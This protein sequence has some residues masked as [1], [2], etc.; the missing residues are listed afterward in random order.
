MTTPISDLLRLPAGPVDL[1]ALDPRAT[2][3][4][5]GKDK[6][7][8]PKLMAELAPVLDDRQ[9]RLFAAGR[10]DPESAPR[11]LMILQGMDTSGKGGV[12]RHAVGLMDPQGVRITGFKAPTEEE[13]SH[14]FLW[15]IER[16]L[17]SPGQVGI[18]DR[19]QYEDVL[20]VRVEQLVDE[21]E[22]RSR[23]D[24]INEFEARL[25][26][27]GTL[28][29]KCF[30]NVSYAKQGERLMERL[31]NPDK[32]W[33]YNPGDLVARSRWADYQA[34]YADALANCNTE[35]APWYVIPADRKWY[36]NWAAAQ[37]LAEQLERLNLGWPPADFDV[38][39]QKRL[40]AAT[41]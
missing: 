37:L 25:A 11:V 28:I 19:S 22:W 7:D 15:R 36:R 2:H 23:Y 20:V 29:I 26:E 39:E 5:P 21:A 13:R 1:S 38:A 34:A 40:L 6:S 9:E 35:V 14:D 30:L 32:Y 10:A 3:G 8:Q 12:I 31:D 41:M 33:K 18:F 17:P 16:A 24:R 4:F 27:Q